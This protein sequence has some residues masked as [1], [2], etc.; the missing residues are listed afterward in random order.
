MFVCVLDECLGLCIVC[1]C[2]CAHTGGGEK[3]RIIQDFVWVSMSVCACVQ[4][5]YR[6]V[7]MLF[8][9][10]K[11]CVVGGEIERGCLYVIFGGSGMECQCGCE[12]V[13]VCVFACMCVCV[14]GVKVTCFQDF[15]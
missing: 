9:C 12:C 13:T 5:S 4:E 3:L 10:V 7:R 15:F 8:V 11:V 6:T 1:V 2:V 14:L